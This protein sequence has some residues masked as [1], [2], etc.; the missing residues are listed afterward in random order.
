MD[1]QFDSDNMGVKIVGHHDEIN[2]LD[3][4]KIN[5]TSLTIWV[6]G[7]ENVD[8]SHWKKLQIQFYSFR[9]V[10]YDENVLAL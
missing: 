8:L 7:H 4:D 9:S 6:Q 5:R 2:L 3:K 10:L 1:I